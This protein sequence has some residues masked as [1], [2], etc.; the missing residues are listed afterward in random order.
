MNIKLVPCAWPKTRCT[1]CKTETKAG[2]KWL[3][4]LHGVFCSETCHDVEWTIY[5]KQCDDFRRWLHPP[6]SGDGDAD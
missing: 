6:H 1:H 4:R 2:D 3:Y 5:K